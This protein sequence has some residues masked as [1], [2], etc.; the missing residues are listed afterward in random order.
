WQA[1]LGEPLTVWRTALSQKRPYLDL[2]D[3]I[4]AI[5]FLLAKENLDGRLYNVVT[6]NATVEDI[7][8][9]IQNYIPNIE[10][11]LTD[12]RIMNQ[13]SSEVSSDRLTKEGFSFCGDLGRGI[14][15]TVACLQSIRHD[16]SAKRG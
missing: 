10:V 2:D 7:L 13:L 12:A 9:V 11:Q 5:R 15:N 4:G 6:T 1:V 8:N 3:A 16:E 14:G